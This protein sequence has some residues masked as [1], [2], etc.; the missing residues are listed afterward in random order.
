HSPVMNGRALLVALLTLIIATITTG[1][2]SNDDPVDVVRKFHIAEITDDQDTLNQT[3]AK[4]DG[5][6]TPATDFRPMRD[7]FIFFIKDTYPYREG[8]NPTKLID[9]VCNFA[10]D[11]EASGDS[12][13]T[14]LAAADLSKV[15]V[16][17]LGDA[18]KGIPGKPKDVLRYKIHCKKSGGHWRITG[19]DLPYAQIEKVSTRGNMDVT[20]LDEPVPAQGSSNP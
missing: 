1:C 9:A 19:F 12:E 20:E 8:E 3:M 14:V 13:A 6:T 18:A 7:V 17:F 4:G 15:M 5:V 2:F 16:P 11:E 10:L